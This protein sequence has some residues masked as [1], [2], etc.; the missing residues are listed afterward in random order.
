M[1]EDD[2][3]SE[4]YEDPICV[5]AH[6]PLPLP[7]EVKYTRPS[8]PGNSGTYGQKSA[9]HNQYH[10]DS[11]GNSGYDPT[12]YGAGLAG[13]VSLGASVVAGY[14]LGQQIDQHWNHSSTPWGT[15]VMILMGTFVGF[16]NLLR[17]VNRQDRTQKK[18]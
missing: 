17:L 5:P 10:S 6:D 7:P 14:W 3:T 1:G 2:P 18:K 9:N 15:I 4:T 11:S 12:R 16:Y 13:S 8:L